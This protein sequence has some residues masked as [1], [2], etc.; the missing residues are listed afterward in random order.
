M[1][2]LLLLLSAVLTFAAPARAQDETL[3]S[4]TFPVRDG[5]ALAVDVGYGEVRVETAASGPASVVVT[6]TGEGVR[7]EFERQRFAAAFQGGRLTVRTAPRRGMSR[8]AD[9][10]RI[11]FTV[12]VPR[13]FDVAVSTGSGN[14]TVSGALAG[15]LRIDTGSGNVTAGD[16][17]GE[18]VSVDTGSGNVRL[19]RVAGTLN[20]DTGSGNVTVAEQDGPADVATGSGN[21]SV[22]LTRVAALAAES[23]S[24]NVT[25]S[26]PRGADAD[27]QAEGG[28]VRIDAALRFAG[29]QARRE[30]SGRIGDGGARLRVESGSGTVALV[31]R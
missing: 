21:V 30:A 31:A 28:A 26:L 2:R 9:R 29:R 24:G 18:A 10:T 12:R 7:A 22:A 27:V 19:G 25:V 15:R 16:V 11:T 8:G 14:V 5:Q 1:S 6:G 4:G 3:F 23:G 17:A 13:R 20:V